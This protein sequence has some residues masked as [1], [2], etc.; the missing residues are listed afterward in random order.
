MSNEKLIEAKLPKCTVF[1]TQSE[2]MQLLKHDP[3]IWKNAL[4]RGK[5]IL[6][7]RK[8]RMREEEK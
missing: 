4:Q 6:R 3:E 2:M 8:Q 5:Y 7:S 1:L